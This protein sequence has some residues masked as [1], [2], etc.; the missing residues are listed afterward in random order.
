MKKEWIVIIMMMI[1]IGNDKKNIDMFKKFFKKKDS[2][3]TKD[4]NNDYPIIYNFSSNIENQIKANIWKGLL[5]IS[6]IGSLT[7]LLLFYICVL[8]SNEFNRP[9]FTQ[10]F[11]WIFWMCFCYFKFNR[12]N[13][14]K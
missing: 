7:Q 8:V 5:V 4:I 12:Y 6:V 9:I 3:K 13:K 11:L 1:G 10:S 14:N 2:D